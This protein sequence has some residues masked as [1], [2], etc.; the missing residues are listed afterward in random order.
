VSRGA[1]RLL[2][3][4]GIASVVGSGAAAADLRRGHDFRVREVQAAFRAHTGSR[5]VR[6]AAA[7][8]PVVTSLRTRPHE[9][10]RFG[11]F[12][13]FVLRPTSVAHLRHVFT[14]G[15]TPDRR[16]IYWVPDQAD[17]WIAVTLFERNLVVAW[18]PIPSARA[19]DERWQRL[20]RAVATFA[21]RSAPTS[22]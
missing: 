8:T 11:E 7:S 20:Q 12:Q 19:I 9:T 1:R 2:A 18:F 16:G 13:L 10:R 4:L 22:R 14:Q 6:F 5:L 3:V 17:G 21:P 15:R